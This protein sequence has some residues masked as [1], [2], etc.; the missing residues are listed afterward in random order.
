LKQSV[1]FKHLLPFIYWYGLM[2][3]ITLIIDYL[4]HLLQLVAVGRYLGIIGTAVVLLSF[5]YSLRKRKIIVTGSPKK[6]LALHEYLSWG[7]SLLILIHAGIHFN[8]VLPW[9]AILMLLIVVASGLTGKYLLKRSNETLKEKRNSLIASGISLEE[10]DKKLFFDSIM[11]DIMKK[12]R[13]VH[14]P[15]TLLLGILSLFHIISVILFGK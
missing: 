11:V 9:L 14:L 7:G 3:L 6:L 5:I 1:A 4:L 8:A 10:A 13:A 2:I 15:M 12:W